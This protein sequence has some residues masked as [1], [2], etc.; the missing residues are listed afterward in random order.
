[1]NILHLRNITMNNFAL[2]ILLCFTFAASEVLAQLTVEDKDSNILMEVLDEG[3]VGSIVLSDTTTAPTNTLNKLYNLGGVLNWNGSPLSQG[4]GSG[5][6]TV[7]GNNM[8]SNLTGN[9]GVGISSP[10]FNFHLRKRSQFAVTMGVEWNVNVIGNDANTWFYYAVGGGTANLHGGTNMIRKSGSNLQ[11]STRDDKISGTVTEQMRLNGSGNLGIGTINPAHKLHVNNSIATSGGVARFSND[12]G[13]LFDIGVSG[14]NV[15]WPVGKNNPY[16]YTENKDL[17][18]FTGSGILKTFGILSQGTDIIAGDGAGLLVSGGGKIDL[19]NQNGDGPIVSLDPNNGLFAKG[20]PYAAE[21]WG[22][23][24]ICN[25]AGTPVVELGEGLDYAEGFDISNAERTPAGNVLIIDP[26]DPGKLT[27]CTEPYD[28]KVAGIVTGANGLGSGV[29]LGANE[30]DSQVALAGRVYCN[31]VA[32]ESSINPGDLLTT[33]PIP[34]FAMKAINYDRAKGA[35][36][37]KAMQ[38]ME[39]GESGKILVLVTLQ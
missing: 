13:T 10:Q 28:T 21:L 36:L 29:C 25:N 37:G 24:K 14:S 39:K 2:F 23:L 34:G 4:G 38:N 5:G 11:F 31:V 33:S 20:S 27:I 6:W 9:L 15:N 35:I 30:F 32:Q 3:T 19:M 12:I 16:I 22:R 26:N 8:Y 18:V 1:M 7:V 17:V